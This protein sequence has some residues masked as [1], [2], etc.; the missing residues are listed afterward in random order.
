MKTPLSYAEAFKWV[1]SRLPGHRKKQFWILFAGMTSAALLET[2]ALGA[3]A[4]FAS[5]VT[6]PQVVLDSRYIAGARDLLSALALPTGFLTIPNGLI[7]AT[8]LAMLGMITL[9]NSLKAIVEYWMARFGVGIEAFFGGWLLQGFLNRPY[10]WHLTCNT[11][12]LVNAVSWRTFLGRN[13]FQPCLK[14]FNSL[15]MVSIM[16]TALFVVQPAVSLIVIVILGSAAVFI[17]R[18]IRSQIDKAATAARDFQIAINKEATMA[19]HGIKDVK[20]ALKESLFVSKFLEKAEPLSRI[21]GVQNFYAQCPVLILETIGFFMLCMA[22]F[23]LLLWFNTSTAYATGTMAILAVTAWKALPAVN[24]ILTAIT[25]VRNSLPY[26]SSQIQYFDLIESDMAQKPAA[27]AAG[28]TPMAFT[29]CIRFDHVSFAYQGTDTPVLHDLSFDIKKGETVGIIGAS[30]AG[31]STLVDLLIGLLH[32]IKGTITIDNT[33]LTPDRIP[34][35]LAVTGYVSQSPYIYDATLAENV[36]FGM[37]PK[38]IDREQVKNCCTMASMDD[39]VHDLAHGIDSFIGERGVRLSG[40]QQQRVAIARALYDN[41][42]VIIFDEATSSLDTRSEKAIQNTIY[43]FKGRQTLV[44]I[45]HR[46]S[47]VEDCNKII[48]LDKG[49]IKMTAPPRDVLPLFTDQEDSN[50]SSTSCLN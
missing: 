12:D 38:D 22:I 5:T 33:P 9:K 17:Y 21:L 47:T 25:S 48:W 3:V 28:P 15:L 7:L 50:M 19:I 49:R 45:A 6:D 13:F 1:Y 20:I 24:L 27:A 41:P 34:R 10:Q 37:D 2:A 18:V 14:I 29:D 39:F 26:I 42:E 4:F 11:A 35:W 8:G 23:A 31:K 43:S 46:L 30:G 36:A 32:P 40:G 44:V 16:V